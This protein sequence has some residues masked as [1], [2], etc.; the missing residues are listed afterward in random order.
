MDLFSL[1]STTLAHRVYHR[2]RHVVTPQPLTLLLL[3]PRTGSQH[4]LASNKSL[5]E[6]RLC[7]FP[8]WGKFL[9]LSKWHFPHLYVGNSAWHLVREWLVTVLLLSLLLR[10]SKI[11]GSHNPELGPHFSSFLLSHLLFPPA[12]FVLLGHLLS[13]LCLP[14][15]PSQLSLPPWEPAGGRISLGKG[16]LCP[17][18]HQSIKINYKIICFIC[19]HYLEFCLKLPFFRKPHLHISMLESKAV[20]VVSLQFKY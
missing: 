18:L 3:F 9:D 2:T 19:S 4:N 20:A 16:C 12:C 6:S 11:R 10:A 1:L 5:F 15:S 8:L 13:P 14:A 7:H 17:D